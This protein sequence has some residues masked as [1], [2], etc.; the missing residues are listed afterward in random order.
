RDDDKI[1]KF[2]EGN[3]KRLLLQDIEDMLLLL[4]KESLRKGQNW[5]KTGQKQEAWQSR[6]KSEAVTVDRGRKTEQNAKRMAENAY[7]VKSYSKFKERRKE[8]GLSCN[9]KKDTS[10]GPFLPKIQ[11]CKTKGRSLKLIHINWRAN[12]V[13]PG[14]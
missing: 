7:T 10:K 8:K 9:F 2:K 11:R 3:F 5:I 13:Q 12:S 14:K 6:E 1:Y 4:V